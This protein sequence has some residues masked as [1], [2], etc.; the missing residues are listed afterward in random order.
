M[1]KKLEQ[2]IA[3]LERMLDRKSIKNEISSREYAIR[4]DIDAAAGEVKKATLN[5]Y[6]LLKRFGD[7][8]L[9]IIF[10][11]LSAAADEMLMATGEILYEEDIDD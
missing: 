11:K 2:R 10:N 4:S 6:R 8:D 5:L 9:M 1:D 3:R 7:D